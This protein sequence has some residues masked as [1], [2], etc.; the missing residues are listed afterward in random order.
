MQA[1]QIALPRPRQRGRP[2]K[3]HS[4]AG[5]MLEAYLMGCVDTFDIKDRKWHVRLP[6]VDGFAAYLGV[7]RD[8]LHTWAKIHKEY[9]HALERLIRTQYIRLLNG[10]L[11]GHY[12]SSLVILMISCNHWKRFTA[13]R[14]WV[15]PHTKG[16]CKCC[17][18]QP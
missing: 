13:E 11:A 14:D 10:G 2:T 16:T 18:R 17:P 8:T 9:R 15:N 5:V 6:T 7:H 4:G 1:V 12:K 3:Y